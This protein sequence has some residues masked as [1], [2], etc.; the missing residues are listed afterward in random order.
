MIPVERFHECYCILEEFKRN[1]QDSDI[2]SIIGAALEEKHIDVADLCVAELMK[3]QIFDYIITTNIGN[4]LERAFIQSNMKKTRDFEIILPE[5]RKMTKGRGFKMFKASGDVIAERYS[6]G[7]YT[8]DIEE[9]HLDQ[10]AALKTAL[11]QAHQE[12]M[13]IVGFDNT[14]D[15]HLLD[16]IFPHIK[17]PLWFVNEE[18][19]PE[20]SPLFNY[21]YTYG[22]ARLEGMAGEYDPFFTNLC[23]DILG[24]I[25]S[26]QGNP[27][28]ESGKQN[29]PHN[30]QDEMTYLTKTINKLLESQKAMKKDIKVDI[31]N[32]SD[33][34]DT[35]LTHFPPN[36]TSSPSEGTG[37]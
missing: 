17:G 9:R 13:L 8:I 25:P 10:R 31:K 23:Y 19:T 12:A 27:R 22:A 7:E 11:E 16:T 21:L 3:E 1:K 28:K 33:K 35:L 4:E 2:H 20:D 29:T 30:L 24:F 34:V 36:S 14:W 18:Q 32:L 37:K 15:G 26:V 5:T 6:I